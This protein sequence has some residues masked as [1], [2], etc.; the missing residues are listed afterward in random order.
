MNHFSTARKLKSASI[1][2]SKRGCRAYKGEWGAEVDSKA[3]TI[4]VLEGLYKE[5]RQDATLAIGEGADAGELTSLPF[6][7]QERRC[8]HNGLSTRGGVEVMVARLLGL[9]EAKKQRN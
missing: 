5:L 2:L 1:L 7:E 4:N 8:R 6:A 9:E 3:I